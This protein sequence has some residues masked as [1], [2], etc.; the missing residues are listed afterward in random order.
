MNRVAIAFAIG[1]SVGGA[2]TFAGPKVLPRAA[3]AETTGCTRAAYL[4]VEIQNLDR[5]KSKPYGEALRRSQ[6]VARHGGVYKF[7]GAPA[8]VLEGSWPEGRSLVVERY[9][10]LDAIKQFWYSAEYQ[11][12]IMPLR[13][14]SGEYL[15][16]AF[17]ELPPPV[18]K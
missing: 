16:T 18:A 17:E 9:P 14:G 1:V 4:V 6:I 8:A 5:T 13:A 15:V 11:K 3:Q 12:D 10:C 2:L 7:S